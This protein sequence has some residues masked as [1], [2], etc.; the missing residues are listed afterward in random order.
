MQKKT[1]HV[2]K[3]Y[4]LL[5]LLFSDVKKSK[6]TW[7][8]GTAGIEERELISEKGANANKYMMDFIKYE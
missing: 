4:E 6:V 8:K 5:K 1:K 3:G 7:L 2:Y